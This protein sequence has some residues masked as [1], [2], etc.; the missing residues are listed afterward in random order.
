MIHYMRSSLQNNDNTLTEKMQNSAYK[1]GL[2]F[3][4]EATALLT[5]TLPS[6]LELYKLEISFDSS[7]APQLLLDQLQRE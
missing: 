1:C 2:L 7:D 3:P 5:V 4:L 6:Q